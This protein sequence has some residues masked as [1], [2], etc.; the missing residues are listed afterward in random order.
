MTNPEPDRRSN[1]PVDPTYHH[2][3]TDITYHADFNSRNATPHLPLSV[4]GGDR[5]HWDS[6]IVAVA[7]GPIRA[8][9]GPST[10]MPKQ[11]E[12][13]KPLDA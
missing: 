2:N 6:C 12:A 5:D 13:A 7:S 8:R 9:G 3:R 4:V 1:V 11:F 10:P